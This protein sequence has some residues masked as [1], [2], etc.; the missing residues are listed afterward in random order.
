M[1]AA[2]IAPG[3]TGASEDGPAVDAAGDRGPLAVAEVQQAL[4]ELRA[5]RVTNRGRAG[6]D[7]AVQHRNQRGDKTSGEYR[8]GG[9]SALPSGWITVLAAH[10]GAGAST[11][12]LAISD[13]AAAT[14]RTVHLVENARP[15]HSGLVAAASVELGLDDTGMWRR[16]LR[17]AVTLDRRAS[18]EASR[19]WPALAGGR[20]GVTVLDLGSGDDSRACLTTNRTSS[21]VVCRPTVPGVRSAEHLLEQLGE[22]QVVVAAI[23]PGRWPG[24]VAASSGPRLRALSI[25]R[26]VVPVPLDQRLQ[27]TGLTDRP[28]PKPVLAAGRALLQ[29]LDPTRSTDRSSTATASTAST[30]STRERTS[31]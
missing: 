27:V 8:P 22:Q 29:L 5:R 17:S 23:G 14:G 24:E 6:G 21:V 20:T 12:A 9:D 2:L 16:G 31:R 7:T 1:S 13:A 4:R 28:L 19:C 3:T 11:V 15:S 26:G 30:A 25:A 18:E 10:A